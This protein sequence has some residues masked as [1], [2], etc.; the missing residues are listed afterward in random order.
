M[1]PI[2]EERTMKKETNPPL[3]AVS[4]YSSW[5]PSDEVWQHFTI[6]AGKLAQELAI[7]ANAPKQD[8][9]WQESVPAQYHRH[10]H[11]FREKDSKRF[12]DK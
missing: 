1:D 4:S 10:V 12:P 7:E 9:P 8:I 2:Q 6:R 5:A 3:G 11:V